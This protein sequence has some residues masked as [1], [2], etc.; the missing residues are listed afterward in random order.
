M[1][2]VFAALCVTMHLCVVRYNRILIEK[3]TVFKPVK[4]FP[5]FHGT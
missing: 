5:S 4:K 3:P 1:V 2:F